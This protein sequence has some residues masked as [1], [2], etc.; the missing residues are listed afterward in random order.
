M[1]Y[2]YSP[3]LKPQQ[4]I[5]E[6]DPGKP[7]MAGMLKILN[8]TAQK[9]AESFVPPAGVIISKK[10]IPT[11]DG[12]EISCFVLEK[13]N[14]DDVAPCI[15]MIHGGAF[16]MTV[17]TSALG[18]AG[19][20]VRRTGAKVFL[21]DYRL[22]PRFRAPVQ[23]NDCLDVWNHIYDN[24]SDYCID[25]DS[26]V[27]CGDS[28]GAALAAGLVLRLSDSGRP[29]LAGL[30]LIYP[31]LDDRIERY[32]SYKQY[33]G[34]GWT[35]N[36]VNAMWK[37]YLPESETDD[38]LYL[39]PMRFSSVG[40]FPATYI[41]PQEIDVFRD[42]AIVFAEK[43]KEEGVECEVNLIKGSY[44]AFDNDWA[45]PFVQRVL[46]HRSEMLGRFFEKSYKRN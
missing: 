6:I 1:S 22:T 30:M 44:H 28:A 11:S 12:D 17:Q 37:A 19:E 32:D 35:E 24:S 31:V 20:Y 13:D 41:E 23:L 36:V 33:A 3:D 7:A 5:P 45:T 4:K 21:P 15:L 38:L 42:E 39:V 16:Y 8:L 46:D 10:S 9:N 27:L 43:L 2:S 25:S 40:N 14:S 34:T 18:V 29:G 26:I